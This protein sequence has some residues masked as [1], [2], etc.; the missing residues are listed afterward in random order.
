MEKYRAAIEEN[1]VAM[2]SMGLTPVGARVFVYLLFAGEKGAPFD[3][4]LSYFK[5]SKSAISNALKLLSST[6]MVAFKT[7]GGQRKRYF[8]SNLE[9]FFNQQVM[10]QRISKFLKVVDDIRKARGKKGEFDKELQHIAL[11]YKMMLA[12]MPI[13]IQRWRNTIEIEEN[14]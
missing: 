4:L 6:E 9:A 7:Y 12:E 3:E 2:E 10:S 8:H 14:T 13:I 11:L 5:V 1:A